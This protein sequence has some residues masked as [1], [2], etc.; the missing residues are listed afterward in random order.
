MPGA[1]H[2]DKLLPVLEL[3]DEYVST[4]NITAKQTTIAFNSPA[5]GIDSKNSQEQPVGQDEYIYSTTDNIQ[6]QATEY[7]VPA[8]DAPREEGAASK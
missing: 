4:D 1:V 3:N 8:C 7:A 2:V 5:H 6:Q